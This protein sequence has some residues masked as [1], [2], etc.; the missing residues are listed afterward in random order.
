MG[1]ELPVA[2]DIVE[3]ERRHEEHLVCMLQVERRSYI[4]SMGLG[5][6]DARLELTGGLA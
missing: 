2:L 5:L 6:N 1:E 3:D 4:S